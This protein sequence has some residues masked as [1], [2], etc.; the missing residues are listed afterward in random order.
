MRLPLV[1]AAMVQLLVMVAL[2]IAAAADDRVAVVAAE[3]FYGDVA[4][5]IG[6]PDVGVTS[7]LSN[8]DEDPHLFEASP[9]VARALA[10]A[11]IVV[12][13]GIDY[14]PWMAKLLG[15]VAG[16]DRVAIDVAALT[17]HKAGDNPHIW[18]DP[19][20]MPALATRLAA[21]LAGLHPAHRAAYQR[22]LAA[23]ERSL[24]PIAARIAALRKRLA[25]VPATATEPVFGY[26]LTA[27]GMTVRNQR[28]QLAVMNNAEPGAGDVAAFETD[29]R[30]HRVRLLV[31]NSQ[32]SDPAARRMVA[33]AKAAQV[34]VVAVTETEPPEFDYQAWMMRELD[35]VAAALPPQ[36]RR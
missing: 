34:P 13:N 14:D 6:G 23:F 36:E 17:G 22:R 9:S 2:P 21:D 11:R 26:M 33:I 15:A 19:A 10:G 7:I 27:L 30:E 35:A 25:G 31:Y 18:Y 8:P 16:H 5:Q 24:R 1:A 20:T 28:F 4:R 12:Y 32:A 29:L 3:N